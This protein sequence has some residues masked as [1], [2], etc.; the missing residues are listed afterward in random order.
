MLQKNIDDIEVEILPDEYSRYDLSFKMIIIGDPGVGK[1]CL[2]IQAIRNV[3]DENYQETVGFEFLT[4]NLKLDKKAVKLQIWDTCGQEIYKSLIKSF[5]RNASLAM[6][7]YSI[8]SKDSFYHLEGWLKDV[9][10]LCNPDVKVFLIGN[11]RDLELEREVSFEEAKKYSE[12][13]DF[14]Y[15]NETSAKNGFNAKEVFIQ[16]GKVLY[17]EHLKYKSNTNINKNRNRNNNNNIVPVQVNRENE[18]KRKK[19]GCC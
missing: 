5:Y 2:S 6:I 1:S 3:F 16:A 19:E 13:N 11:K 9:R 7:V 17:L 4:F 18:P 12:E 8:D 10:L 14:N 15:F